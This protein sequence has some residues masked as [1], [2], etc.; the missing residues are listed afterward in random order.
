MSDVAKFSCLLLFVSFFFNMLLYTILFF[1]SLSLVKPF[2]IL[3][4]PRFFAR[5]IFLIFYL[6]VFLLRTVQ[7]HHHRDWQQ[8]THT[9]PHSSLVLKFVFLSLSFIFSSLFSPLSLSLVPRLLFTAHTHPTKKSAAKI[10]NEMK[11]KQ[12]LTSTSSPCSFFDRSRQKRMT[13]RDECIFF[14]V[15]CFF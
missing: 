8:N 2:P 5:S 4:C 12:P 7:S 14:F 1:S 15:F 3:I 11:K 13:R 9:L 10:M 6:F